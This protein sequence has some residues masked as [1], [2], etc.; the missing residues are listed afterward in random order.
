MLQ[1][2]HDGGLADAK[3]ITY[4]EGLSRRSGERT[5]TGVRGS[6]DGPGEL[7]R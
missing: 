7:C 1:R 3:V 4:A 5:R 2:Y 6:A